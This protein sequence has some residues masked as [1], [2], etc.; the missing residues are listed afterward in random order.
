[1]DPQDA[2]IEDMLRKCDTEKLG[3]E[4]LNA[5]HERGMLFYELMFDWIWAMAEKENETPR[6]M[7]RDVFL[8][9]SS[10]LLKTFTN[11][12]PT[13]LAVNSYIMIDY[14]LR[15]Q[16]ANK[17]YDVNL[18]DLLNAE[19]ARVKTEMVSAGKEVSQAD[20][21]AAEVRWF[22]TP[23]VALDD[24]TPLRSL[25]EVTDVIPDACLW[26]YY[27]VLPGPE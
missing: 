3:A 16:L 21:V 5:H 14:H 7:A 18:E 19:L 4:I 15:M 1:M 25:Q 13:D 2:L 8:N 10:E 26:K 20:L 12:I 23:M 6:D 27:Q 9:A 17:R 22:N 24:K 11:V